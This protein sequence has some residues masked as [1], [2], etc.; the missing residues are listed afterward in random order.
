MDINKLFKRHK[1][2]KNIVLGLI[3]ISAASLVAFVFD[4]LFIDKYSFKLS[5]I[6]LITIFVISL[7][8]I[9]IDYLLINS[10]YNKA[11]KYLDKLAKPNNFDLDA[12]ECYKLY[13]DSHFCSPLDHICCNHLNYKNDLYTCDSF[14]VIFIKDNNQ[15]SAAHM[16][17]YKTSDQFLE[18]YYMNHSLILKGFDKYKVSSMG[19]TNLFHNEND[20]LEC[21]QIKF[22]SNFYIA[23]LGNTIYY[24]DFNKKMFDLEKDLSSDSLFNSYLS[25]KLENISDNYTKLINLK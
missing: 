13:K 2:Y 8:L 18:H 10:S 6:I 16:Y 19:N 11:S 12:K 3:L 15:R 21:I 20:N 22:S 1:I 24:I 17:C 7:V 25:N 9:F 5:E 14:D 4:I 23:F